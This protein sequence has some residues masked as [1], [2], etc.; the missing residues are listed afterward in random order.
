M[1]PAL[2]WHEHTAALQRN[3]ETLSRVRQSDQKE[4]I[5]LK[6]QQADERAQL[7]DLQRLYAAEQ[8]KALQLEQK[9][10]TTAEAEA[11]LQHARLELQNLSRERD[12]YR[13]AGEKHQRSAVE[14]AEANRALKLNL[15][16]Q[17]ALA[18]EALLPGPELVDVLGEPDAQEPPDR[19]ARED[20]GAVESLRV[21]DAVTAFT[22]VSLHEDEV[23]VREDEV[24][25]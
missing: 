23:T 24:T 5:A 2:F 22:G 15:D 8:A 13:T 11:Q 14:A 1:N 7:E 9:L 3:Y 20:G 19:D 25:A 16:D 21:G 6:A 4:F 12:E 10:Q 17:G 18:T